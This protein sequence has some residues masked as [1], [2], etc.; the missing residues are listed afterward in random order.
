MSDHLDSAAEPLYGQNEAEH[1]SAAYRDAAASAR[2]ESEAAIDW[3]RLS[4]WLARLG[5]VL[6]LHRDAGDR[7]FPRARLLHQGVLLL[8]HPS[9]AAFSSCVELRAHSAIGTHG[10]REWLELIDA[11]GL[12]SAR[13]YL[14][15]DADYLAWDAMLVECAIER[16]RAQTPERWRAHSAFMRCALRRLRIA[17]RAQVVRFPLLQLPCLRVLGVRAPVE[18]SALGRQIATAI[19]RDE[20]ICLDG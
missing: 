19:T 3:Y 1:D 2:T 8:D 12:C 7:A 17:W 10:P 9:L 11:Q 6:W 13:L 15:P 4:D 20:K 18:L 14:L 5:P 16:I